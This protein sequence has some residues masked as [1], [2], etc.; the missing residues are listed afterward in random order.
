MSQIKQ[1]LKIYFLLLLIIFNVVIF[2]AIYYV[3]ESILEVSFLDVGQGDAI[4][5]KAP[6]GRQMLIDGGPNNSVLRELGKVMPFYDRSIDI[7]MAT[8][9]DQ[10]HIGGLIAV[11]ERFDVNLFIRTNATSS[12]SVYLELEKVIKDKA[13]KTE[14]II[15]PEKITLGKNTEFN[16]LFPNQNTSGWET[17]D[18]S[19]ISKLVYGQTS[20]LLTGDAPLTIEKYLVGKYGTFLDSDVLKVGHHGSKNSSSELFIGTVSP[21]YSVISVGAD[22]SYG[23]PTPEVINILTNF[24]SQ[25]LKTSDKGMIRFESDGQNLEL[26]K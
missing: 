8:H 10:D 2:Y 1:N 20:F 26:I 7:V 17:N 23:H 11:L 9:A 25:I 6:G 4:F 21:A 22:N 15:T 19:I 3:S 5:I 12:S 18:S 13:I 14:I 16:I 24:N